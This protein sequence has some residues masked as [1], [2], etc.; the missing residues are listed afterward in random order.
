MISSH[1]SLVWWVGFDSRL[2]HDLG[3]HMLS[4][5]YKDFVK[6]SISIP[7]V[8]WSLASFTLADRWFQVGRAWSKPRQT[9]DGKP[10]HEKLEGGKCQT[11]LVKVSGLRL[12]SS[13]GSDS[14]K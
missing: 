13:V 6:N 4:P 1:R 10:A 8:N 12:A 11:A 7:E 5:A 2:L 9:G 14:R 3:M